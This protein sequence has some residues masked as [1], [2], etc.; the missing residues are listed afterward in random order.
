MPAWLL[1]SVWVSAMNLKS[2]SALVAFKTRRSFF[3]DLWLAWARRA[4]VRDEAAHALLLKV[5]LAVKDAITWHQIPIRNDD[6]KMEIK[7]WPLMLP[8]NLAGISEVNLD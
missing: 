7:S 6:G 5:G 2:L 4:A 1:Q 3:L 8:H